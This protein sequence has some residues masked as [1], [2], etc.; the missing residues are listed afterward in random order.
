MS[1]HVEGTDNSEP[2]WCRKGNF[3]GYKWIK[4]DSSPWPP[5][6]TPET[7]SHSDSQNLTK[8]FFLKH[9]TK[10]MNHHLVRL[11]AVNVLTAW[12]TWPD[13]SCRA[14]TQLVC[15]SFCCCWE[16]ESKSG[17]FFGTS[18]RILL[19]NKNQ[20]TLPSEY[21]CYLNAN[22]NVLYIL[23]MYCLILYIYYVIT[24]FL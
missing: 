10:V 21:P 16:F 5:P 12:C 17:T 4:P 9:R 7:D 18:H 11:V 15:L 22:T 6:C 13:F 24:L 14:G 20:T 2:L 3:V 23:Y 1:E 19:P 8:V